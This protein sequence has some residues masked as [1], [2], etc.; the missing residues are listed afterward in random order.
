M[1]STNYWGLKSV[2]NTFQPHLRSHSRIVNMTSS[3]GSVNNITDDNLRC[4]FLSVSEE[5]ELDDLMNKFQHDANN[6]RWRQEGWP[7]CAYT[8]SKI[9]VNAYTRILQVP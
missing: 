9:A 1:L 8:V 5:D 7:G 3:L 4:L 2:V 6:G